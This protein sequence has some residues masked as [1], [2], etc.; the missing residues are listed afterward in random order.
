MNRFN[1]ILL[2]LTINLTGCVTQFVPDITGEERALI[3]EA[4]V[5]DMNETY[6]VR[7]S[8]LQP[9]YG[10]YPGTYIEDFNVSVL[11][12]EGHEYP[13]INAYDGTYRSDSTV[14]TALPGRKYKLRLEGPEHTYESGFIEMKPVP[15]IDSLYAGPEINE[16]YRPGE[17]TWGY[18]VSLDT[19]DPSGECRFYMWSF[20][21][22]W[23][24]RYPYRSPYMI[25]RICWKSA[26]SADINIL[27]TASLGESRVIRQPVTFITNETDRLIVKYSILVRQHSISEEEFIYRENVRKTVFESGGLYN[28]IPGSVKGNIKCLDDPSQQVLGF[29]A[30]SAVSEKRLFIENVQSQFPDFY[31]YCRIDTVTVTAYE[32]GNY[33]PDVYILSEWWEPPALPSY[34]LSIHR[35]CTDCSLI[36]TAIKPDYWD[37]SGKF[38]TVQTTPDENR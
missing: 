27:S 10:E 15:C 34:I 2:I 38:K 33:G 29:F 31:A 7:I 35:E 1:N 28:A 13:F 21:E 12:D 24:F 19:Y 9:V 23:E 16:F 25:N 36:G 17:K 3:V 14:F 37:E 26:T 8:G 11:D 4:R 6:V 30:V 18:Q 32:Q 20:R 5:T 22:T